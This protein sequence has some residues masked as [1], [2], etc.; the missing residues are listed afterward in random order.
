MVQQWWRYWNERVDLYA[1]MSKLSHVVAL[2]RVSKVVM[3]VLVHTG[4]V[5]SEQCVVF[6]TQDQAVFAF[7]SSAPHYWWAISKASSMRA[8]LRYTPSD[9]FETLPLPTLSEEMRSA[10]Q[11]LHEMRSAFMLDRQLGLT[12]TYNLVHDPDLQD[13]QVRRLRERHVAIDEAVFKAYGWT[14][15]VPAHGHHET[16]QGV[17]W[18][19][20]PAVQAELLDRLL[21]LNHQRYAEEVAAGLHD[22][23][24]KRQPRKTGG[25]AD[26]LRT[27][28]G[29]APTLF[30]GVPTLFGEDS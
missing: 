13:S 21:E 26:D 5:L 20:A 3:P 17:R 10:G 2:T 8:D 6:A 22:K 19:V 9:V 15:L 11:A 30:G 27:P 4:Q 25:V 1:A 14:D 29:G 28:F 18:T 7:L 24:A 23:G 12:K 16:R